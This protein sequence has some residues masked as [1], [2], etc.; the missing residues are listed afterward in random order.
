MEE[1]IREYDDLVCSPTCQAAECPCRTQMPPE[2]LRSLFGRVILS[3]LSVLCEPKSRLEKRNRDLE[4]LVETLRRRIAGLEAQNKELDAFAHTVAHDLKS[5]VFVIS[6]YADFMQSACDP[7]SEDELRDCT[8]KIRR[9]AHKANTIIDELLLLSTVPQE[10]VEIEPLDMSSVV[11]NAQQRLA[12][13]VDEHGAQVALPQAWPVALGY[14]PWIEE[15]WVNYMSNA[16][17]YGG[18][19]PRIELGAAP[20][21]DFARFWVRDN[22][23]GLTAEEQ[24]RLFTPFTRLHQAHPEGC[25]LGLSIV[26]RIVER[27]DGKV[28]IESDGVPGQGSVFSFTLPIERRYRL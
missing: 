23:C 7:L 27:L 1:N 4:Q 12:H 5:S 21:D 22:G 3:D 8:E 14:G 6:G 13:M 19:P 28:G 9:R 11:G 25:G 15:V 20:M 24:R 2:T 16:I 10:Q 18:Q 26:R 17:K